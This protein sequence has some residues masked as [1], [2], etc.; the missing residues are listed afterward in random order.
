MNK[1]IIDGN[2]LSIDEVY[3]IAHQGRKIGNK[4]YGELVKD[5]SL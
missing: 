5:L 1:V 4:K 2:N 3:A